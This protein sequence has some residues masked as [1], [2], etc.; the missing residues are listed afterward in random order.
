MNKTIKII[1]F[2][3]ILVVFIL[4]ITV[5]VLKQKPK[6]SN[7]PQPSIKPTI[8]QIKLQYQFQGQLPTLA[9]HVNV[10]KLQNVQ[11]FDGEKSKTVAKQVGFSSEIT[12][13]KDVN[14][15]FYAFTD[16]A[17]QLYIFPNPPEIRYRNFNESTQTQLTQLELIAKAESFVSQFNSLTSPFVITKPYL[18]YKTSE[19]EGTYYNT[20]NSNQAKYA[21]VDFDLTIDT[22]P[23]I[24]KSHQSNAISLLLNLDGSVRKASISLIK[25]LPQNMGQTE[26][27]P[28]QIALQAINAGGGLISK[29]DN[30]TQAYTQIDAT[31][32]SSATLRSL[33]LIYLYD[34]DT[35]TLQPYYRFSGTANT[36]S[37]ELIEIE[38]LITALPQE[39]FQQKSN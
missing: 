23:I 30:P 7:I 13:L 6:V 37:I 12:V 5:Y 27:T 16:S 8:D 29:F 20:Q 25:G 24:P 39:V 28:V 32:V 4:G 36:T 10:Y 34:F 19:V 35:N 1:F 21:Q 38:V 17:K 22:I 26:L 15:D 31:T 9:D 18:Q 14:G 3:L 2:A 11:L 33:E